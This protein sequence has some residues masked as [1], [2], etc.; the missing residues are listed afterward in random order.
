MNPQE[1]QQAMSRLKDQLTTFENT[2]LS[3]KHEIAQYTYL[4]TQLKNLTRNKPHEVVLPQKD[5]AP[6]EH[7][8]IRFAQSYRELC[9][10]FGAQSQL[11]SDSQK[12]FHIFTAKR[13]R[14]SQEAKERCLGLIHA[15]DGLEKLIQLEQLNLPARTAVNTALFTKYFRLLG[16]LKE[17]TREITQQPTDETIR[18]SREL[19]DQL[20][21]ILPNITNPDTIAEGMRFMPLPKET[22]DTID[23]FSRLPEIFPLVSAALKGFADSLTNL[24]SQEK[25]QPEFQNITGLLDEQAERI[26]EILQSQPDCIQRYHDCLQEYQHLKSEYQPSPGGTSFGNF[27]PGQ[28]DTSPCTSPSMKTKTS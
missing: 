16:E 11:A 12:A 4:V 2:L 25:R 20:L 3:M 6:S 23:F 17:Y 10:Q 9:D 14:D 27:F 13:V 7:D 5:T 19:I 22:D 8:V 18:K 24:Q 21:L 28:D 15:L 26:R 1:I